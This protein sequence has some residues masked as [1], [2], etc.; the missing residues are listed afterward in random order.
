MR[1][2][3]RF[4][5]P[6]IYQDLHDSI[7]EWAAVMADVLPERAAAPQDDLFTDW[8]RAGMDGS[9]MVQETGL[10]I[11]GGAETT[12]TVIAHGLRALC[13]HPDDWE[14]LAEQVA[15]TD[16]P[17]GG[18]A[19]ECAVEELIR[20]V[21]PLN[22]MFRTAVNEVEVSG[23]II[24][25]GDRV[26]LV[27]P[28]ANRDPAVFSEP[29]RFDIRRSPNHHVAFGHGT[30]FCLGANMARAEL[31][32]LFAELVRRITDLRVVT[33]PDVEPNIFARAVTRF[34]VAFQ[35]RTGEAQRQN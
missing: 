18:P 27:Y 19:I 21:T 32:M 30:H 14:F 24:E 10:M 31:R 22:N 34:D 1:I 15:A 5:Q 26:A 17:A 23:T 7:H 4:E 2:D 20:W 16:D 28:A 29:N 13:D 3:V 11:A 8:L 9:T 6:E 12:R 35:A 25:A 33:E